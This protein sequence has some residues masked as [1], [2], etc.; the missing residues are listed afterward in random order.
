[1]P[2]GKVYSK[3]GRRAN[4]NYHSSRAS[5]WGR[6]TMS[7]HGANPIVR[8]AVK[9]AKRT[10]AQ[11]HKKNRQLWRPSFIPASSVIKQHNAA[12][13]DNAAL[14]GTS[15]VGESGDPIEWHLIKPLFLTRAGG[16]APDETNRQSD[17]IWARNCRWNIDIFPPKTCKQTFQIR[18]VQGYF[19]G[20]AGVGTQNLTQAVMKNIYPDIHD[21]L[22][23]EDNTGKK[24]F[25]WKYQRT[26]TLSPKQI[27]D[28]DTEE[29]DHAGADRILVANWHP[30]HLKGNFNF[31]RKQ[32]FA[33][34]DADS[35]NGWMP[36]IGIQCKALPG[37]NQFTRPSV[38]GG[39]N[40]GAFPCPRLHIK[41][42]TYFSD[43]F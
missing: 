25:Y 17:S 28:E 35:L 16:T 38:P 13:Y 27:Y 11:V 42:T 37:G 9:K 19:K 32:T 30:V 33:N 34:A 14:F 39:A 40:T 29:G 2:A 24:D 26:Y 12:G 41:S 18:I 43:T 22:N 20:D 5:G 15:G 10:Q 4:R 1:M 21:R 7:T 23:D 36:V 31:N 3:Y 6:Y 8:K